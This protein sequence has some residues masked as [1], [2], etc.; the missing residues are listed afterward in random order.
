MI[1]C[2]KCSSNDIIEFELD[3]DEDYHIYC[4]RCQ[5][6]YSTWLETNE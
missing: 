5:I 4:I 6:Y 3:S 1:R 2:P